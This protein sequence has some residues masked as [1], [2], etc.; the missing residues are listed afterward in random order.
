MSQYDERGTAAGAPAGGADEA[1]ETEAIR[2][3]IEQ[4][5]VEMGGTLDA[6]EERL[7]PETLK[8]QATDVI[9][10]AAE[11]AK[12]VVSTAVREAGE[13]AREVVREATTQA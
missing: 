9:Q 1:D 10:E 12:E 8:E 13:Q 3:E 2:V 4:T 7:G 5:R 6:I 11:Q